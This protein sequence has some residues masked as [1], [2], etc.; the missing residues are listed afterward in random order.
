[1]PWHDVHAVIYGESAQ[2]LARHFIEYWNHAKIDYEGTKNK[3]EG[4]FLKPMNTIDMSTDVTKSTKKLEEDKSSSDSELE[5]DYEKSRDIKEQ[6]LE[7]ID[8][9]EEDSSVYYNFT[10]K[11]QE[12]RLATNVIAE[13][14]N[15][16]EEEEKKDKDLDSVS[17][18]SDYI[19]ENGEQDIEDQIDIEDIDPLDK[20]YKNLSIE[21]PTL[22]RK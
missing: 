19:D 6:E 16:D 5:T 7:K 11:T 1:M 22:Q 9:E 4:T 3:K 2:D 17:N 10:R 15:E 14:N 13:E 21:Q 20:D 18:E 12:K 8:E